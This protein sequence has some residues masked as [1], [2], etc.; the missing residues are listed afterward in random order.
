MPPSKT[1]LA[2]VL[3]ACLFAEFAQASALVISTDISMS[4]TLSSTQGSSKAS[5]SFKDDKLVLAARTDAAAF[6]AS[7]GEIRSARLEAALQHI[8]QGLGAVP[9]TDLQLAS[10]M[11]AL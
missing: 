7:A 11:L 10:A 1:R 2:C 5:S 3:C 4:L 9:H 8:R 6:V